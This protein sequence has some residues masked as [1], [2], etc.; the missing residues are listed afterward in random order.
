MKT[1]VAA[2]LAAAALS[3]AHAQNAVYRCGNTY[4]HAPCP[5][6]KQVEVGDARSAAQQ[7][8]A[9]RVADDERRLATDMRRERLADE[10]ARRPGGAAS[11]SG[12]APV[13]LALVVRELPH[14]RKHTLGKSPPTTD[15]VAFDPSS[16]KRRSGA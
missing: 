6:A 5:D 16:R 14:K 2:L 7:S 1:I 11:L 4:S 3:A 15:F 8:E 13:R 12:Q 10:H 9:R